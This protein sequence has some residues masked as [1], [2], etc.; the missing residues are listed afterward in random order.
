MASM[1]LSFFS[2]KYAVGE[3]RVLGVQGNAE[4]LPF[5]DRSLDFCLCTDVIEHVVEYD[6]VL[7]EIGRVIKDG[8]CLYISIPYDRSAKNII[9]DIVFPMVK[10]VF[11][12]VIG[13]SPPTPSRGH[14]HVFGKR[15]F[16]ERLGGEGFS[17]VSV[18]EL[19][20]PDISRNRF[21]VIPAAFLVGLV[22]KSSRIDQL[23]FKF[24]RGHKA[25]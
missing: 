1:D 14:M 16:I 12:K 11:M 10:G 15:E 13:R 20:L 21:I 2:V 8:G 6:R 24:E 7:L 4:F 23:I 18:T 3:G 25:L 9:M 17:L 22:F 5:R 19:T